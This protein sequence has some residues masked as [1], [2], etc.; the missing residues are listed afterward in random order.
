MKDTARVCT[1]ARL[2]ESL[3]PV[4]L[5]PGTRPALMSHVRAHRERGIVR[6]LDLGGRMAAFDEENGSTVTRL[7]D[8]MDGARDLRQLATACELSLDETLASVQQ[9][10]ELAVVHNVGDA[11]V[12]AMVFHA[13]ICALELAIQARLGEAAQDFLPAPTARSVLGSLI[14]TYHFVISNPSH[15]SPAIVSAPSERIRMMWSEYLSDEYWHGAFLRKGLRAAGLSDA[16]IDRADPLP[17]N[18]AVMNFL[19]LTSM[20]DPIAYAVCLTAGES[21]GDTSE[22]ANGRYDRMAELVG[23]DVVGPFRE[24]HLIDLENAHGAL[25]AE[26]FAE[27]PPLTRHQQ[28]AISRAVRQYH[29][30]V[31]EESIQTARYY[32]DASAPVPFTAEASERLY[33]T[34]P[35]AS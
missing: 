9:L 22:I 34:A 19:K 6:K 23:E 3:P 28:D 35:P 7:L 14:E 5:D 11:A 29:Q 31:M 17:A 1:W 30:F 24:H 26:L 18:L 16:D 21:L 32:N 13:H 2:A 4:E 8:C 27:L 12:P 10:Y 15:V 33:A 25:S 20:L